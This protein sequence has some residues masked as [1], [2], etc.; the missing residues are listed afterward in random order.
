[1][2]PVPHLR[3]NNVVLQNNAISDANGNFGNYGLF[4][5][6]D[7][8]TTGVALVEVFALQ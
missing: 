8:N 1:M 3:L 7:S 6:P 4:Q 5:P 2:G